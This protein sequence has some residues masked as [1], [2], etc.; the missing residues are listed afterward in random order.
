MR[1]CT[2]LL[3]FCAASFLCA[4]NP[5]S[6]DIRVQSTLVIVPVTV[7]DANNRYVLGLEKQDFRIFEED[8]E[9]KIKQF[10]GEDAP[11]S[12]GLIVDTSGS[13]GTK[14]EMCREAVK[15]FL[16][17][18]NNQDEAFLV[19][20]N[21]RAEL[22]AGITTDTDQIVEKL[23]SATAGG[24]T[25]L[26]DALYVG[27]REMKKAKNPRKTLLVISDGGDNNSVFSAKEILDLVRQADVQIYAMGVFEPFASL[28]LSVSEL[29]GPRLLSGIA[30]QTGGRAFA[31]S[32]LEELPAIAGRIGIE[33]R[34]QYVLAYAPADQTRN[35]KYRKLAVKLSQPEGLTGLKARWRAGYYAPSGD[36]LR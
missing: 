26:F 34:N 13:I 25:A 36:E 17:T 33:L 31:A 14:L 10:S 22:A 8:A 3:V 29:A 27:L 4:Q 11:L 35:G 9:Q 28:G 32:T 1:Y 16:K 30:E 20:F 19:E 5:E 12:V 18:M 21:E 7:T 6:P 15:Q 23:S 24:M 2:Y